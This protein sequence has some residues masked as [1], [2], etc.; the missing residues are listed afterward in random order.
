MVRLVL[1]SQPTSAVKKLNA[2]LRPAAARRLSHYTSSSP[3]S[4]PALIPVPFT[5]KDPP[6]KIPSSHRSGALVTPAAYTSLTRSMELAPSHVQGTASLPARLYTT[7]NI[8]Y[9][10]VLEYYRC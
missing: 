5:H 8:C 6:P 1:L 3:F 10:I 4:T 9:H 2:P 7:V